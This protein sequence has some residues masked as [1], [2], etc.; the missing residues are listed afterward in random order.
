MI[1]KWQN[2]SIFL[3]CLS[4]HRHTN[5][6]CD[7]LWVSEMS[8]SHPVMSLRWDYYENR[9]PEWNESLLVL[10]TRTHVL[11]VVMIWW[12]RTAVKK[13]KC[14]GIY[15]AF[16]F[17]FI[18]CIYWISFHRH[19]HN[20]HT[21]NNIL[22]ERKAFQ[23]KHLIAQCNTTFLSVNTTILQSRRRH[24]LL[25]WKVLFYSESYRILFGYWTGVL[26]RKKSGKKKKKVKEMDF[27]W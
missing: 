14:V 8:R 26:F 23:Q 5:S 4:S 25:L 22:Q 11:A 18:F 2:E 13:V 1:L 17:L 12:W 19:R 9:Y 16:S 6:K 10:P 21:Y 7:V 15:A 27:I 24:A 3:S 20:R